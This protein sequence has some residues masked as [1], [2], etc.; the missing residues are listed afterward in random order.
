MN[1]GAYVEKGFPANVMPTT[2]ASLPKEQLEALEKY[3][4]DSAKGAK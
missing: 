1:P 4:I 3:L 2:F